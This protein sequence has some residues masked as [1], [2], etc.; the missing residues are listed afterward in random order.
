MYL[1]QVC[2]YR[3]DVVQGLQ[4]CVLDGRLSPHSLEVR[5]LSFSREARRALF[6]MLPSTTKTQLTSVY[7]QP[8]DHYDSLHTYVISPHEGIKLGRL[9]LYRYM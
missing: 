6:L 5:N 7:Q 4:C 2:K 8:W 9:Y 3:I 1:H